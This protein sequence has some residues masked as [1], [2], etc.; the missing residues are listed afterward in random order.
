MRDPNNPH[1]EEALSGWAKEMTVKEVI[2][3]ALCTDGAH[4]KQ[5]FLWVLAARLGI[6]FDD[7]FISEYEPEAGIAP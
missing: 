2:E 3:S 1:E 6:Y 7:T 5:C 4:H